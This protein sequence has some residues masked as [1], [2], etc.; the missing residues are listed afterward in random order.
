MFSDWM[1]HAIFQ[2]EPHDLLLDEVVL[3]DPNFA[4]EE[5]EHVSTFQFLVSCS[6]AVTLHADRVSIGT[7]QLWAFAAVRV[8]AC[9]TTLLKGGLVQDTLV[10]L[11]CLIDVTV[12]ANVDGIRLRKRG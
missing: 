8:M 1:S 9:S 6:R 3:G 7:Q 10:L 12:Q 2:F 4:P 11:I 5:R